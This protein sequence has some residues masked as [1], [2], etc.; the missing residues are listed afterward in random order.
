MNKK[1]RSFL[2]PVILVVCLL[3]VIAAE[4]FLPVAWPIAGSARAASSSPSALTSGQNAAI[5]GA[6]QILLLPQE[7]NW[8][9]L[10]VVTR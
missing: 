6:E 9:Y 4:V 8:V 7:F 10:P 1:I 5:Q 3:M 2:W